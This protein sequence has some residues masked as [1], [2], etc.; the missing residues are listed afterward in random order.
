MFADFCD[1]ESSDLCSWQS[2]T[3]NL[4]TTLPFPPKHDP[5]DLYNSVVIINDFSWKLNSPSTGY[6]WP[7][8]DHTLKSKYGSYLLMKSPSVRKTNYRA[9]IMSDRFDLQETNG[10]CLEFYY[11][12]LMDGAKLVVYKSESYQFIQ[13]VK[14]ITGSTNNKWVQAKLSLKPKSSST[15]NMFIYIQGIASNPESTSSDI[16][17][18]D[19]AVKKGLCDGNNQTEDP[20]FHC[21]AFNNIPKKDILKQLVCDFKKDC[22]D[23]SDELNCGNCDFELGKNCSYLRDIQQDPNGFNWRLGNSQVGPRTGYLGSNGYYY[24][25]RFNGFYSNNQTASL[26]SPVIQS[27]AVEG[28][29]SFAYYLSSQTASLKVQIWLENEKRIEGV[30]LWSSDVMLSNNYGYYLYRRVWLKRMKV[31]FR[32]VF[33][34]TDTSGKTI[35]FVAIDSI[36]VSGCEPPEKTDQCNPQDYFR[37]SNGA[38]VY[39]NQVC[40]FDDDC[41]DGSDE[42]NCN[43]KMMCDF[44]N[45]LCDWENPRKGMW[46]WN[47]GF[48]RLNDGP[49]H[50]HTL[51]IKKGHFL[52]YKYR[53][54]FAPV[55]LS[56][57]IISGPTFL[58]GTGCQMTFNYDVE[59]NFTG[60]FIV[61][62]INTKTKEQK[63]LKTVNRPFDQFAYI[64]DIIELKSTWQDPF[65]VFFSTDIKA[66]D[67]RAAY[68]VID[69]IS[70]KSCFK[71]NTNS[72]MTTGTPP[73]ITIEPPQCNNGKGFLC[74]KSKKCLKAEQKCNFMNDCGVGDN[75]DKINCGNCNF[76][77]DNCGW[78]DMS[79]GNKVWSRVS[80]RYFQNDATGFPH[81]DADKNANGHFLV[82][83]KTSSPITYAPANFQSPVIGGTSINC[84]LRLSYYAKKPQNADFPPGFSVSLRS[85]LNIKIIYSRD[86]PTQGWESISVRL[87]LLNQTVINILLTNGQVSGSGNQ[88]YV[89]ALIDNIKMVNCGPNPNQT[90]NN[91]LNCTFEGTTCGWFDYDERNF[92]TLDWHLSESMTDGTRYQ[93]PDP[94]YDHTR[95]QQPTP[96]R[97]GG[98]MYVNTTNRANQDIQTATLMSIQQL[99]ISS[100]CLSFWYHLYGTDNVTFE[101]LTNNKQTDDGGNRFWVRKIPQSNN[102]VNGQVTIKTKTTP[103]IE[104]YYL[105]FRV[106]LNKNSIVTVALD[107]ITVR[108]GVCDDITT[109]CDFEVKNVQLKYIKLMFSF[110]VWIVWLE[111]IAMES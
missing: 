45:G 21:P 39:L 23:G 104:A 87:P 96:L 61:G 72:S 44:E 95:Q 14:T 13:T 32:I 35:N 40:D 106:K 85:G 55:T 93:P 63:I 74:L 15:Q 101:V 58:S 67:S 11:L 91:Q 36:K 22:P 37:C 94:G 82:V 70:F 59:G 56:N 71:V 111:F 20:Y 75:S 2:I 16:A 89:D 9:T 88:K 77:S 105:M 60:I 30:D 12:I 64:Y 18:D 47:Q 50:D 42:L 110:L 109:T 65:Q 41:N 17:I 5:Q 107:D 83:E 26:Y 3:P 78:N 25:S 100:I 92:D 43:R 53:P 76:E 103:K 81:F 46:F 51:G 79:R 54:T 57:N 49:T 38:C 69:D 34:A 80:A 62:M 10:L 24:A 84:E 108:E 8:T 4:I 73:I 102:W 1:F 52:L 97:F 29:V 90:T 48:A 86:T 6:N 19:I 66:R 28:S 98:F 27:C 31:P 68:V 7:N 99:K 33:V